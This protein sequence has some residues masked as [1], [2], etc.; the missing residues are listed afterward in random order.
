MNKAP[1]PESASSTKINDIPERNRYFCRQTFYWQPTPTTPTK[2]DYSSGHDHSPTK[3][4]LFFTIDLEF[5]FQL[6]A[7][8]PIL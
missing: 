5:S 4:R 3:C 1:N 6:K 8:Q 2:E 7:H